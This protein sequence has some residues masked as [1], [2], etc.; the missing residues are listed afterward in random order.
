MSVEKGGLGGRSL[1]NARRSG[2]RSEL[3]PT[4]VG[5]DLEQAYTTASDASHKRRTRAALTGALL[6]H[7]PGIAVRHRCSG[8]ARDRCGAAGE[9]V[10]VGSAPRA[11]SDGHEG[12]AVGVD[13]D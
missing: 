10:D 2:G 4:E 8:G 9:Q 6:P 5:S 12:D 3:V 11:G 7:D 1:R 13:V